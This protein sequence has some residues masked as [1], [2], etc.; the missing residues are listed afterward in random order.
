MNSLTQNLTTIL[1][2]DRGSAELAASAADQ[3]TVMSME[4]QKEGET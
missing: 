3:S 4:E 1:K 2:Q